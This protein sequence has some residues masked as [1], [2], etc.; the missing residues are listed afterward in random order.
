VFSRLIEVLGYKN[1][2]KGSNGDNIDH[3][4]NKKNQNITSI[5]IFHKKTTF[6]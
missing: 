6:I 5:I 2:I 1:V 3:E 4:I